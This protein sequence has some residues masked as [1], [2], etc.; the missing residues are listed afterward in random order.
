MGIQLIEYCHFQDV[1][2]EAT[3]LYLFGRL[4]VSQEPV[5]HLMS[6]PKQ[7]KNFMERN[8]QQGCAALGYPVCNELVPISS[9]NCACG[10]S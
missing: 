10:V 3:G 5:S 1:F 9:G 8:Y 2:D 7:I 6:T 4:S